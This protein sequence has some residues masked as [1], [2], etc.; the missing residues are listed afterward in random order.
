M[1]VWLPRFLLV[2]CLAFMACA[3]DVESEQPEA[4]KGNFDPDHIVQVALTM[5][6][7]DWQALR[8]QSRS[9]IT[10]FAGDCRAEPFQ[11]PYT[12]FHASITMDDQQL[13]DVGVRKKGFIGSQSLDKPGFRINLDEYV[14]GAELF[15][16]DNLTLNN[17]V[18]D[19]SLIRQC[20]AYSLFREAGLPASRC[21]FARVSMNGE[22]LG[23]YVHV[24]PVKRSF[25]RS[26]F[27][28][29]E[30]HL[31]EGTISDFREDWYRTYE[32]KTE[33]TDPAY[34][35]I[36]SLMQDIG[37]GRDKAAALSAHFDLDELL[38][39]L[40]METIIGHWDGYGGNRNNHYVYVDAAQGKFHFIPWG[41]DGVMIPRRVDEAPY[42]KGVLAHHI[43]GDRSLSQQYE[44]R[45]TSLLDTVWNEERIGVEI[46][47]MEALLESEIELGDI[48]REIDNVR[49]FV[50][51]RRQALQA[52]LPAQNDM[53]EPAFC[54]EHKGEIDARFETT[55]ASLGTNPNITELGELDWTM[56]WEGAAMRFASEGVAAGYND[57]NKPML[58]LLGILDP[59]EPSMFIPY[60]GFDP[61]RV[62]TGERI[63]IKAMGQRS[64][65]NQAEGGLLYRGNVSRG[66]IVPAGSMSGGFL[67]FEEFEKRPGAPVVGRFQ[68]DIY[69]WEQR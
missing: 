20:L 40:A 7:S 49:E 14:E 61:D 39:F 16:K 12:Y 56:Q 9:F 27:G 64:R 8:E 5:A 28:E 41:V 24:E 45:L 60:L 50:I 2:F 35:P 68:T 13:P 11:S 10:E 53:L 36:L 4:D 51:M 17:S 32:P 3:V 22:D 1:I 43:L 25:L 46:S 48:L 58:V 38:T 63:P 42:F 31:Y 44:N 55:W 59:S 57:Q 66:Q 18:Q 6:D 67:T 52:T 69:G 33:T 30:G 47:R 62:R 29:D 15:G 37:P 34:G 26:H 54:L 23:I 19:S 65:A 21:N